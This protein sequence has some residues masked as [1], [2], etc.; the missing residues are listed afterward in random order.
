MKVILNQDVKY[1]GEEGDIKNVAAGY[2]RNYLFPRSFA[3]PHNAQTLAFFDG[4]RAEIE[5]RKQAKRT[6]AA[7]LKSRLETFEVT[8]TMPAGPNGKL[9]GAVTNHVVADELNKQGFE[10]ERKRI[11]IPG[12]VIKHVG[13]YLVTVRLYESASAEVP[14]IVKSQDEKQPAPAAPKAPRVAKQAVAPESAAVA[15]DVVSPVSE[16]VAETVAEAAI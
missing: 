16:N 4:R 5:S 11:E 13:K 7:S 3:V 9:Y 8:V 2:A 10:V 1:L 6:D 12:T 14:L 15:E